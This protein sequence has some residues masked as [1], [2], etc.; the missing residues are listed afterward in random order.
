MPTLL[1]RL[2]APLQSWGTSSKFDVRD[3][4]YYPSKSG[5]IGMVAAA[6]GYDRNVDKEELEELNGLNFGV[7]IDNRG[8]ILNDYQVTEIKEYEFGKDRSEMKKYNS[9]ISNRATVHCNYNKIFLINMKCRK[10]PHSFF[11]NIY[12]SVVDY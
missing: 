7:R 1:L 6:M 9:N 4:D 8:T 5:V 3:T 12:C 11:C 2:N 10:T